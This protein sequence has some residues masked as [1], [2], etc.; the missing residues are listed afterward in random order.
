MPAQGWRVCAE[1]AVQPW[2][3]ADSQSCHSGELPVVMYASLQVKPDADASPSPDSE[4]LAHVAAQ[5]FGWQSVEEAASAPPDAQHEQGRSPLLVCIHGTTSELGMPLGCAELFMGGPNLRSRPI[6]VQ[7]ARAWLLM[8]ALVSFWEGPPTQEQ[9]M[10]GRWGRVH[11]GLIDGCLPKPATPADNSPW[12]FRAALWTNAGGP[13]TSPSPLQFVMELHL[14]T[15]SLVNLESSLHSTRDTGHRRPG[16][17]FKADQAGVWFAAL[18]PGLEGL[19]NNLLHN[20][21]DLLVARAVAIQL[22]QLPTRHTHSSSWP[23]Y[24]VLA[25]PQLDDLHFAAP[26]ILPLSAVVD[27]DWRRH[28]RPGQPARLG[29]SS[30]T[31]DDGGLLNMA[32]REI[33][34]RYESVSNFD[35]VAQADVLS[36][37]MFLRDSQNATCQPTLREASDGDKGAQRIQSIL[38]WAMRAAIG[39]RNPDDGEIGSS[40]GACILHVTAS[41]QV[42][43][44]WVTGHAHTVCTSPDGALVI[45]S[46]ALHRTEARWATVIGVAVANAC[47]PGTRPTTV[48][49]A[50]APRPGSTSLTRSDG[51]AQPLLMLLPAWLPAAEAITTEAQ[52]RLDHSCPSRHLETTLTIVVHARFEVDWLSHAS[53]NQRVAVSSGLDAARATIAAIRRAKSP[54]HT[55]ACVIVLGDV[56]TM[57]RDQLHGF[58]DELQRSSDIAVRIRSPWSDSERLPRAVVSERM[59]LSTWP[60]RAGRSEAKVAYTVAAAVDAQIAASADLFVG[61]HFSSLAAVAAV[62]RRFVMKRSHSYRYTFTEAERTC[63]QSGAQNNSS[64]QLDDNAGLADYAALF[65]VP[66]LQSLRLADMR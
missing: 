44:D 2:A 49:V 3:F 27:M 21:D 52:D 6:H 57:S 9:Q 10:R 14:D 1:L 28:C 62:R 24:A 54:R 53:A 46:T 61:N 41:R 4:L 58:Y 29:R 51:L 37:S 20:A 45:V 48:I 50:A 60:R 8:A 59:V 66:T 12:G 23:D 35:R 16:R 18:T 7:N 55:L 42:T 31:V 17:N 56:T 15:Y 30:E 43:C 63:Q 26:R 65:D 22:R 40:W 39:H 33:L 64:L 13:S 34:T 5:W 19:T 38:D 25:R 32:A 11:L 47:G 36:T